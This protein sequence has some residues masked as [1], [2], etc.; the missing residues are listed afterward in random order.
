MAELRLAGR[1]AS[2]GFASG[3][4]VR[5]VEKKV[6]RVSSNDPAREADDLKKAISDALLSISALADHAE[7]EAAEILGFQLVMLEDDA[8]SEAA[9]QA[10]AS[11]LPADQAWREALDVEIE[12]YCNGDDEYFR[13][14]TADLEDIRDTVLDH[15]NGSHAQFSVPPSAI[16]VARD[17]AP[18]RFLSVDWSRGG[19]ILLSEGS[20]TSHV[21]M[22]ARARRVPMI[23][24]LGEIPDSASSL[25]L[26]DGALGQVIVSPQD[27][28]RAEFL[29]RQSADEEI[30]FKATAL[31][32]ED[33]VTKDGTRISVL[34][35]IAGVEDLD[36]LDPKICD[37]IGL[38]RTEF[39]F[40]EGPVLP[41]E[42]TQ[43][44]AYRQMLEWAGARPVTIRTL[45]A[46]GDKPIKG[47][48]VDGESNPFL[49]IRGVRLSLQR[50]DVFRVQIRALLRAAPHGKLKVMVPMITVPFELDH[51]RALFQGE[52]E[53]LKARGVNA[54]MPVLGMMV[55]VPA[56]ALA[57]SHFKSDFFSIGSNDLVQYTTAAGRDIGAVASLA[58]VRHPAVLKL[59]ELVAAH[60]E[61]SG[62][63]VSL[64]G[65]AGGDPDLI[66][67]LLEAGLRS[68]SVAPSL[69]GR[70]KL[71]ITHFSFEEVRTRHG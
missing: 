32:A 20:P 5:L 35:N 42:D 44:Q 6:H 4:V 70:V 24:G 34:I 19:A 10:I 3:P 37:G 38:V 14:R 49:G 55:E 67:L 66:P 57:V 11:G 47:L 43:Y 46:G 15:L 17:L 26:V 62:C 40:G 25:I 65:D 68:L 7:G 30:A 61:H 13:A 60:G 23:V 39:L 41:D 1:P 69:V 27:E 21:A 52:Y 58:D 50:L 51:V 63:D 8:L 12:I 53:A 29:K 59:I 54:D 36:R 71:A 45:D 28:T 64:C 33:A 31:E 56:A 9:F 48:T 16:I 22:L 18:S 2:P